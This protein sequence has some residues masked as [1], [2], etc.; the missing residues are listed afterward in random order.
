M[1][2]SINQIPGYF[3]PL[4]MVWSGYMYYNEKDDNQKGMKYLYFE[5]YPGLL[6][7]PNQDSD[8]QSVNQI[9]YHNNVF[10]REN[11]GTGSFQ[12]MITGSQ[13]YIQEIQQ[14]SIQQLRFLRFID[15]KD[16]YLK[17]INK[18]N[19]KDR[20][21]EFGFT[22]SDQGN[23]RIEFFPPN[24]Q[25]LKKWVKQLKKF[26]KLSGFFK[27]YICISSIAQQRNYPSDEMY[28]CVLIK[29]KK[30]NNSSS[31][32]MGNLSISKNPNR[33]N[34]SQ[35]NKNNQQGSNQFYQVRQAK[36]K[37]TSRQNKVLN[38]IEILQ[39]IKGPSIQNIIE[40]FHEKDN[41]S[42]YIVSEYS[43]GR[44]LKEEL[45][46]EQPFE[47]ILILHIIQKILSAVAYLHDKRILHG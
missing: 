7:W 2:K 8:F 22:L 38:E 32:N 29:K 18:K 12:N 13:R 1:W 17:K 33:N 42:L 45:A 47:E 34:L 14:P 19:I 5:L 26:C 24:A 11:L 44:T 36:M 27:K 25:S 21:Y 20:P 4:E 46:D 31:P 30:N 16:L 39:R 41:K 28:K 40:V 10:S 43:E 3:D 35:Y 6:L 23:L 15:L 9:F 37:D